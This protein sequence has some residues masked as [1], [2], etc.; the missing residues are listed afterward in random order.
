[1]ETL[2]LLFWHQLRAVINLGKI[3]SPFFYVIDLSFSHQP[4]KDEVLFWF[5]R[6]AFLSRGE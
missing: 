2:V 5:F 1:M 4:T 3:F 6:S